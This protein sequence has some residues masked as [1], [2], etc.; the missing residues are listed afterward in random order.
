MRKAIDVYNQQHNTTKMKTLYLKKYEYFPKPLL[1][2]T[3]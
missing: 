1:P 2:I 3:R